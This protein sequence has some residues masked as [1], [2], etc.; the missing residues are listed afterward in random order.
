V[1]VDGQ[2]VSATGADID[3][4]I[5]G[6]Y[7]SVPTDWVGPTPAIGSENTYGHWGITTNDNSVTSGLT[8]LYDVGGTGNE[9]VSASTSPVEVFR[10]NGPSDG[11][12]PHVGQTEV[13][14]Q[15]QISALQEA[16]DDYNATLTYVATPV[17]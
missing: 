3:G 12:T 16:G 15:I 8:D 10:H 1:Q 4:F 6:A 2:L 5:D 14:Y 13:G 9:Y 7:T 17:F 11:S